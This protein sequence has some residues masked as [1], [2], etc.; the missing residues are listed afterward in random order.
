MR[1]VMQWIGD[2]LYAP[3]NGELVG[4]PVNF[5]GRKGRVVE[6]SAFTITVEWDSNSSQAN[7]PWYKRFWRFLVADRKHLSLK[8]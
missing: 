1:E 3:E 7:L 5:H 8:R 4:K 6:N 2:G